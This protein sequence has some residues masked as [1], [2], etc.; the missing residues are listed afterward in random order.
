[1]GKKL[2]NITEVKWADVQ[3][4]IHLLNPELAKTLEQCSQQHSFIKASYYYG[5]KIFQHHNLNFPTESGAVL[6]LDTEISSELDSLIKQ[7]NYAPVPLGLVLTKSVEQYYETETRVMPEKLF[8]AGELIGLTEFLSPT[9]QSH[10]HYFLSAGARSTFLL[11]KVADAIAHGRLKK[12]YGIT[13]YPP[14][15]L[16]QQSRVFA[17]LAQRDQY[18]HQWQ[19]EILFFSKNWLQESKL[20][21][22]CLE[23]YYQQS[24]YAMRQLSFN[25]IWENFSK[26]VTRRNLKPKPYSI[27]TLKHIMAISQNIFPGFV[28]ADNSESHIPSKL[29]EQAYI[30]SYQLKKY[31]P[32]IMVPEYFNNT[33]QAIYYSMAFPTLLEYAPQAGN[34]RSIM[35]DIREVKQLI[36][37][38]LICINNTNIENNIDYEFFHTD[39]D[40]LSEIQLSTE[41]LKEDHELVPNSNIY[42]DRE[43]ADNSPFFRGCIRIRKI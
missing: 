28:A 3:D 13:A 27:N 9:E 40:K 43:F 12:D 42:H 31:F 18:K 39:L 25:L 38:L 2:L 29:I 35:G 21:S 36:N 6:A 19:C 17:D 41:M 34:S 10:N 20:K 11:P 22:F 16:M 7:L 26:E 33:K 5:N 24:H 1:M 30:N 8:S 37:I 14:K 15:Q 23:Q 32:T 4:H